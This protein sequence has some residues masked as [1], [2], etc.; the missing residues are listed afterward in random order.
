MIIRPLMTPSSSPTRGIGMRSGLGGGARQ[1]S[2]EFE[3]RTEAL[4]TQT[5]PRVDPSRA[6]TCIEIGV[7]TYHWYCDLFAKAGY[8][9][10]AVEPVPAEPFIQRLR[11]GGILFYEAVVGEHDGTVTV[12]LGKDG[13]TNLSSIRADWWAA[14]EHTRTVTSMTLATV[15]ARSGIDRITCLKVDAEGSEA[16]ILRQLVSFS[17]HLLP[18]L[19]VFE[20]GAAVWTEGKWLDH[21]DADTMECLRILRACGYDSVRTIDVFSEERFGHLQLDLNPDTYFGRDSQAGN[22]IAQLITIA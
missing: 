11:Q 13:D 20:F 2:M 10:V 6:G 5:L 7:G 18:R 15:V 16:R 9:S 3:N 21:F 12:Y 1:P 17:P 4:L 19:I 8:R 22:G 14:T